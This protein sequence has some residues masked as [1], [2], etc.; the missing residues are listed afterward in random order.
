MQFPKRLA[1]NARRKQGRVSADN[2]TAR[3]TTKECAK[4][5]RQAFTQTLAFLANGT[6]FA[7][8]GRR[9]SG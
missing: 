4:G 3:M 1:E 2:H 9:I 7:N 8:V 6:E 5:I